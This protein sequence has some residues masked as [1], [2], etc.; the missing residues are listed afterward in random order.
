MPE[1]EDSKQQEGS[2]I[3]YGTATLKGT[4]SPLISTG[5]DCYKRLGVDAKED[6]ELIEKWFTK[7][8][9]YGEDSAV[10]GGA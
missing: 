3:E 10:G 4:Y 9:Y 8:D 7:A 2:K 6:A 5:E 1:G